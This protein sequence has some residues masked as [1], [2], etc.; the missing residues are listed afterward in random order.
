M[1]VRHK[2]TGIELEV[3]KPIK[4]VSFYSTPGGS[5]I[6]VDDP[7]WEL[8][9]EEEWEDISDKC[10]VDTYDGFTDDARKILNN[11]Q[12]IHYEGYIFNGSSNYR[13]RK[14]DGL[15]HGPAFIVEKRKE[16]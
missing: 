11:K 16:S 4:E 13:L 15:H 8:V 10:D 7:Q 14:I 2:A 5:M 1:K 3:R 6:H 9:K 12:Y